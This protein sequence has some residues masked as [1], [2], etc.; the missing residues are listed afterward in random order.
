M[1]CGES[2]ESIKVFN[3]NIFSKFRLNLIQILIIK[4]MWLSFLI[5][6]GNIKEK[7]D[8]ERVGKKKIGV[9]VTLGCVTF[10]E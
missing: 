6:T 4:N 2:Q 5:L 8:R 9:P 7:K 1:R 10:Q 3:W